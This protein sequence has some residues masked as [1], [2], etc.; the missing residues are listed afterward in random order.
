MSP[1]FPKRS[2]QNSLGKLKTYAKFICITYIISIILLLF[3]AFLLYKMKFE[4][5]TT[6]MLV[7]G[8]YIVSCVFGGCCIG[9]SIGQRRF[10]WGLLFGLVYVAILFLISLCFQTETN[11]ETGHTITVFVICLASGCIG[12]M[13]S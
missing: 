10:L 1:S 9:K 2:P 7:Y 8:I 4:E 3:V 12:G 11:P 6:Q 13:L 5:N